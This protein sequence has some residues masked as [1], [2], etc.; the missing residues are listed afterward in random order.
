M[1]AKPREITQLIA[2]YM[3]AYRKANPTTNGLSFLP[4]DKALIG[5]AIW[6][7]LD[8]PSKDICQASGF[9]FM[10]DVCKEMVK[11]LTNGEK[12]QTISGRLNLWRTAHGKLVAPVNF[13]GNDKL[14]PPLAKVEEQCIV[15]KPIQDISPLETE[16]NR[17]AE[18][19]RKEAYLKF[20]RDEMTI[21]KCRLYEIE[22]EIYKLTGK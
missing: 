11:T 14:P 13:A 21:T 20:L 18:I 19:D 15:K 8:G 17:Q 6:E 7:I 2:L 16:F 10:S 1:N 22:R 5:K 3:N 4:E 12:A 9:Y